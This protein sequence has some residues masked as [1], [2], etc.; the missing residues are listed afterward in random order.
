MCGEYDEA[1]PGALHHKQKNPLATVRRLFPAGI[2][3]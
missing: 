3:D 2:I 1:L